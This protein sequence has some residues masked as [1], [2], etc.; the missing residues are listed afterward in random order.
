[1]LLPNLS[2]SSHHQVIFDQPSPERLA[3]Y[4]YSALKPV[5]AAEDPRVKQSAAEKVRGGDTISAENGSN[6]SVGYTSRIDNLENRTASLEALIVRLTV[7]LDGRF[8]MKSLEKVLLL[9]APVS[10]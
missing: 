4:L 9:D 1:M 6:M 2:S 8:Q 5:V 7:M 3:N 10:L